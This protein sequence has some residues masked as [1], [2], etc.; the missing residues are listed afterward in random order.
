MLVPS[1]WEIKIP[2]RLH[3]FLWLLSKNKLFTRDN[4]GKRRKVEDSTCLFCEDK[5]LSNIC[6]FSCAVAHQVWAVMS[7]IFGVQLGDSLESIGR[8]WLSNKSNGV[9]NIKTV[10][11]WAIT[12]WRKREELLQ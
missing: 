11:K 4:L 1:I 5:S 2:P 10:Q 12:L 3:Y 7:R 6:F 9:L 8:F